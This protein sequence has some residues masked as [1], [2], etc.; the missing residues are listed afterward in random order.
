VASG[1]ADAEVTAQ[2]VK[3]AAEG[4]AAG[5]GDLTAAGIWSQLCRLELLAAAEAAAERG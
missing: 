3:V 1:P 5:R 2:A 4:D